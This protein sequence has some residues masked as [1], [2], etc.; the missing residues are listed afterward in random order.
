MILKVS[1]RNIDDGI[2]RFPSSCPVALALKDMGYYDVQVFA[3]EI[4]FSIPMM[5]EPS[6][7]VL[8]APTFELADYIMA[9]DMGHPI[10]PKEFML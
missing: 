3:N 5:D 9:F 10:K 4:S 8:L 7:R 1:Y 2:R 6:Q